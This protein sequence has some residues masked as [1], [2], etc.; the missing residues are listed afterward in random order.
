ML[1]VVLQATIGRNS[2]GGIAVDDV[3]LTEG[4]C[5]DD[6][7]PSSILQGVLVPP[8]VV[9]NMVPALFQIS[10]EDYKYLSVNPI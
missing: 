1:Q 7:E 4:L 5:H 3:T 9:I 8:L 6:S 10:E 2:T